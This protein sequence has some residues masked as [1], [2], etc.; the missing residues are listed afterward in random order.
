[1]Q[2]P[3]R[4]ACDALPIPDYP[5]KVGFTLASRIANVLNLAESAG[6]A[7]QVGATRP[8]KTAQDLNVASRQAEYRRCRVH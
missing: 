8:R 6:Q 2:R 4:T 5:T 1:V 7:V 3:G